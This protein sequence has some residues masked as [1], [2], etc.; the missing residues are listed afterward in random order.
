MGT[1]GKYD[2]REKVSPP[3][4]ERWTPLE[5]LPSLER[6]LEMATRLLETCVKTS[7]V[8]FLSLGEES[9]TCCDTGTWC[10]FGSRCT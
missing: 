9:R 3:E 1:A 5:A 7:R 10:T 2:L 4:P 6:P 8:G